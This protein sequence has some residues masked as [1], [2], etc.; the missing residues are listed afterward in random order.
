MVKVV[1]YSTAAGWCWK[2]PQPS[3]L[4]TAVTHFICH[5]LALVLL[6][7]LL[8]ILTAKQERRF[9]TESTDDNVLFVFRIMFTCLKEL[10]ITSMFFMLVGIE[11]V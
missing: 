6:F 5:C 10:K 2:C 3:T 8:L 11:E 1:T 7:F 4:P 9:I